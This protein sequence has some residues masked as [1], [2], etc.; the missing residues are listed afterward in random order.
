[1]A[2]P[3]HLEQLGIPLSI[4]P[5]TPTTQQRTEGLILYKHPIPPPTKPR[6]HTNYITSSISIK[7]KCSP[8]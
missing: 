3:W 5:P 2:Y 8:F 1:M 7:C 6:M 4:L